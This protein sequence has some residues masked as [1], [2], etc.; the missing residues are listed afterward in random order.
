MPFVEPVQRYAAFLYPD[1]PKRAGR[2]NLYC[3][4]AKLYLLFGDPA[5]PLPSNT[6]DATSKTGVGYQHIDDYDRYIDLVRN[7][8]PIQVTFNP[9]AV[10]P[11]FVV[12]AAS[13]APGEGEI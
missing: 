13:E 2:I 3:T 12:Y 8:G 10:P 7:E 6:Y 11:S 5:D 4:S 9:D 1:P